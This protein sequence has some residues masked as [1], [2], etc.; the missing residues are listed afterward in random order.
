MSTSPPS[1]SNGVVAATTRDKAIR[2]YATIVF[3]G[4]IA[5]IGWIMMTFTS[6]SQM[7]GAAMLW[8]PAALQL[9][10]GVWLGPVRGAIAGGL[11]AYVAGILATG[12]WGLVDI[13]MNPVAGGFANSLLPGVLFSALKVDPTFGVSQQSSYT[14]SNYTVMSFTLLVL[15]I[16]MLPLVTS[17]GKWA[18]LIASLTL[19]LAIPVTLGKTG[20]N[21]R[22]ILLGG[23]ITICC[24]AVSAV[25]GSAGLWVGGTGFKA[26]LIGTGLGWFLG[27]LVSCILGLYM[28]AYYTPKAR[29]IGIAN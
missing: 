17:L 15:I 13:I 16:G 4:L 22:G 23:I 6:S 2:N 27:D 25:I 9:L 21:V 3:S 18:Y 24:S 12:G 28:L 1:T 11:G 8:L 19:V 26:A 7:K 14:K 29:E 5:L 20:L 10:A